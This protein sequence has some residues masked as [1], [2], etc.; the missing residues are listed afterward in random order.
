MV[1]QLAG[2]GIQLL[3]TADIYYLRPTVGCCTTTPPKASSR[4]APACKVAE[5]QLAE[6]HFCPLQPMLSGQSGL[7]QGGQAL[8]NDFASG[9]RP[10]GDQR[11]RQRTTLLT[12]VASPTWEMITASHIAAE[13]PAQALLRW[14]TTLVFCLPLRHRAHFWARACGDAAPAAFV[15]AAAAAPSGT[16]HSTGHQQLLLRYFTFPFLHCWAE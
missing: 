1:L 12:A 4:H 7:R 14:G 16:V 11:R 9:K 6:Y 10:A 3:N 13:Q 2:G 5:K 15:S 8:K